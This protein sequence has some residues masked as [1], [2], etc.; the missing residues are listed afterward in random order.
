MSNK[1]WSEYY[2]V[3]KAKPPR[4]L[5]VKALAFVTN[6]GKAIDIGGGALNDTRYLLDQ[7]FEVTVIDKS[8]LMEQEAKNIKNEKLLAFTSAFEDFNFPQN[9]FDLVSAMFALPFI[10]PDHFSTVFAK[11]KDSL[12]TGGVFCGQFFG[13]RDE[14]KTNHDMTFHTKEQAHE[15][16]KDMES[17]SFAEDE[18]DDKTAKGDMKHWHVFHIIA[19]KL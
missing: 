6:K 14:W 7:G 4:P 11:I 5:L 15:L 16:L 19:R 9:E 18:K 17:I 3:T 13:D 8:P 12:K 2:K 1:D 10:N